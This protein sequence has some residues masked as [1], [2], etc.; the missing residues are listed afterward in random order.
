M[1]VEAGRK[2]YRTYSADHLLRTSK[3]VGRGRDRSR[4]IASC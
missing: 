3:V 4:A 1:K 2:M